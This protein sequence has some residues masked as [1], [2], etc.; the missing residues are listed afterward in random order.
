M[1][2]GELTY[3]SLGNRFEDVDG[4]ALTYKFESSDPSV[5]IASLSS[6]GYDMEI[7]GLSAG[8]TTITVTANDNHGGTVDMFFTVT[9][10]LPLTN[11]SSGDILVLNTVGTDEIFV[12]APQG[13]TVKLYAMENG[14]NILGQKVSESYDDEN[15]RGPVLNENGEVIYRAAI[16][17]SDVSSLSNVFV[18]LTEPGKRESVRVL[19]PVN[20]ESRIITKDKNVVSVNNS[21]GF[22]SVKST[23]KV[24]DIKAAINSKNGTTQSYKFMYNI[25]DDN[26]EYS[27]SSLISN[28]YVSWIDVIAQDGSSKGQYIIDFIK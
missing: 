3:P 5:A 1:N 11:P 13:F 24:S 4:D 20:S 12:Y 23:V 19:A 7:S 21:I 16:S 28:V 6:N 17:L 25:G 15:G 2:V 18:T 27:D 22:I 8:S 26:Y 14:G 10:T 9:V